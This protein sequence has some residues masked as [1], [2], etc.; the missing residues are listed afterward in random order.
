MIYPR[1][2]FQQGQSVNITCLSS[3]SKP[4]SNL[5]LYKNGKILNDRLRISYQFDEQMKKNQTKII[6]TIRD[7]DSQ[8]DEAKIRCEQI[9]RFVPNI[10][11]EITEKIRVLCPINSTID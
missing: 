3:S 9:Y 11:R 2:P 5:I 1:L 7:P 4:A 6:Y 8:W 10:R